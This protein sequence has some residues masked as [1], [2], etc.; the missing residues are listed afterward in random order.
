LRD[1]AGNESEG[2]SVEPLTHYFAGRAAQ[3]FSAA[4]AMGLSAT[5]VNRRLGTDFPNLRSAGY[6]VEL[7]GSHRWKDNEY[8]IGWNVSGTHVRGGTRAITNAQLSSLRY[9]QRPDADHVQVDSTLTSLSGYAFGLDLG[10]NAGALRAYGGYSYIT[11]GFDSNDMG[12]HGRV[13]QQFV[14]LGGQYV[15]N[16]PIGIFRSF[17]FGPDFNGTWSTSGETEGIWIRPLF[18]Y[19]NFRNNWTFN[20]NPF[21]FTFNQFSPT[22]LR[23]GPGLVNDTW[24]NSFINLG[25]DGRKPVSLFV[26]A[27]LGG[28]LDQESSFWGINPSLNVRASN[29]LSG[30][31]GVSLNGRLDE[32]EWVGRRV[33]SDSTHYIIGTIDQTTLSLT[34]RLDWTLSPRLSL[35][36]YAQPFVSAGSYTD[37]KEV[38]NPRGETLDTRLRAYGNRLTCGDTSCAWI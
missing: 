29:V 25:S 21:A 36:L 30:S 38:T 18:F 37:F 4:H 17:G 5:A 2:A 19:A 32:Q 28:I 3:D 7:N 20:F 13:D 9:Y 1:A 16:Q 12:F 34:T 35:Q 10:K 8:T 26:G 33:V 24:H 22:A 31:L 11:P 6:A 14:Y 27:N 23:G 15:R